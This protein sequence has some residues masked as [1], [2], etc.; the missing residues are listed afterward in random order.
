VTPRVGLVVARVVFGAAVVQGC[1]VKLD[2]RCAIIDILVLSRTG[3]GCRTESVAGNRAAVRSAV[4][5][6]CAI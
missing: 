1:A 4:V 6:R 2:L 3:L 5:Q